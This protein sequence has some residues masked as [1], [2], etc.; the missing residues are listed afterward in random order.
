ML[1]RFE[2]SIYPWRIR[3]SWWER[4]E[5]LHSTPSLRIH[6]ATCFPRNVKYEI[7]K[8]YLDNLK[9][10]YCEWNTHT[11]TPSH[12]HTNKHTHLILV[13]WSMDLQEMGRVPT[14]TLRCMRHW[15]NCNRGYQYER[16][17]IHYLLPYW[18]TDYDI[19]IIH[20]AFTKGLHSSTHIW[21]KA[22]WRD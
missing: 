14:P 22:I 20:I 11:H 7:F 17:N 2:N 4:S 10:S 12:T 8:P 1:T 16:I 6:E 19:H 13:I 21:R 5:K 15:F 9:F 18:L 3:Y